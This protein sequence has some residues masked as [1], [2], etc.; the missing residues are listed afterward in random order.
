MARERVGQEARSGHCRRGGGYNAP[1]MIHKGVRE[2][3]RAGSLLGY[4]LV[5]TS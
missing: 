1:K 3:L 4:L 2:T 5:K